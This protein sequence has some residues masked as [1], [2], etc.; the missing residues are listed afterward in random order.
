MKLLG[1]TLSAALAAAP[2]WALATPVAG[3]IVRL[4]APVAHMQALAA[5]PNPSRE[6]TATQSQ[7]WTRVV[8]DSG[9]GA[10]SARVPPRL[11]ATGLDQQRLSFARRLSRTEAETL[12]QRL[13]AH[14][15]VA[16][17]ELDTREQ[18][19]SLP[20]DPYFGPSA[21]N[22]GQWWLAAISGAAGSAKG[23]RKRGVPGFVPAWQLPGGT[24]SAASVVA[25]LDTGI[26]AHPDLPTRRILPGY[27]FIGLEDDVGAAY[28]NDGDG[29]DADPTDPGDWVDAA[30]RAAQPAAFRDC[31]IEPSTWHGTVIAGL[32]L[33]EA[34]NGIGGAGM[35][36]QGRV[37]PVRVAGKCGARVSDIVDGMRWAA[38]LPV[39]GAPLNPH[40][41]RII[42]ISFGGSNAC[43]AAYQTAIDELRAHGVVVV[44]A[45][46]NE[47]A[48]PS[49]PANC[50]GVIGVAALN[51]DGFKTHYSNFG[52]ALA[53]T[54]LATVGG[55]DS[56]D[57][58]ARWNALADNGILTIANDGHRGPGAATY[59]SHYGTSFAA[60][61]VSGVAALMLSVNAGLSAAQLVEGLR[62][63]ARPH[64]TSRLITACSTANPG[65][66]L[67]SVSTCGAGILDADQALRYAAA[68][69]AYAPPTRQAESVDHADVQ[70]ALALGPDRPANTPSAQDWPTTTA[71]AQTTVASDGAGGGATGWLMGLLLAFATVALRR[72][73]APARR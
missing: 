17:A 47:H 69:G 18:R 58:Q 2:V 60:P 19:L 23:D 49:R 1:L 62:L 41:A 26:T 72:T 51:R 44:A 7:R 67:C 24:G 27:D 46:G 13:A 38:G 70:Q 8:D 68:P 9:L 33:A 56:A 36:R 28:A 14:P 5:A 48:A 54:G 22:Q 15:E 6:N 63:S 11:Q 35:Q 10:R 66:C 42:N 73:A 39:A 61:M 45:A 37:L 3:L 30:D 65:R 34:D 40:P 59:A 50:A 12:R 29:R 53:A 43:G 20:S 57:S 4:K 52:P 16:W 32:L 71:S 55:D 64:V 25:V 21:P 31:A